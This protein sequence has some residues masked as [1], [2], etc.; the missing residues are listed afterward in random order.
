MS[1]LLKLLVDLL[2]IVCSRT[3]WFGRVP[4]YCQEEDIK[5]GIGEFGMPEKIDFVPP[6][7]C[8]YVA[9]PDRKSAYKI[10]SRLKDLKIKS[11]QIKVL[12]KSS[13]LKPLLMQLYAVDVDS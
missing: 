13:L 11:R 7:G 10:L 4:M 5:D 2:F 12:F 9:M 1:I 8:A 6:R 3:L